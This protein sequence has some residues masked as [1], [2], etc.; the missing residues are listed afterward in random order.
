MHHIFVFK[1]QILMHF[2]SIGSISQ[3]AKISIS[4]PVAE[5]KSFRASELAPELSDCV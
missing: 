3:S 1:V 5:S 2:M 4:S